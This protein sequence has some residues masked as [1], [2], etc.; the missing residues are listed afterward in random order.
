[1]YVSVNKINVPSVG[2]IN[3]KALNLFQAI[4]LR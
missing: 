3:L 1:M 4:K 2:K